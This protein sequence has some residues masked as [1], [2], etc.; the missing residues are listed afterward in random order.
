MQNKLNNL[1]NIQLSYLA[2]FLDAEGCILAQI[3]KGDYPY[4]FTIRLSVVFYQKTTKHWYFMY[5]KK[6]INLGDIKVKKDGMVE[7]G[8]FGVNLVENFLS[9]IFPYLVLKKALVILI[10]TIIKGL[11][12]IKNKAHFIEVCK[13]VDKVAEYNC[14]KG[15]KI[16]SLVVQNNLMLPVETK[17]F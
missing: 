13:L 10:F 11:K 16:T 7:Y 9:K 5:L 2:G 14:S 12:N 6:L 8:I 4:N 15:R 1:T 17:K 3:V